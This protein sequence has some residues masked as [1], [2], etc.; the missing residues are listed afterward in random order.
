M[1]GMM[2]HM[3]ESKNELGVILVVKWGLK[4]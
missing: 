2:S 1:A 3:E 4:K